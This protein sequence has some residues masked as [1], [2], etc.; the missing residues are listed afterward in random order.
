MFTHLSSS[1][2]FLLFNPP[3]VRG[4][5]RTTNIFPSDEN[6]KRMFSSC[7]FRFSLILRGWE[8]KMSDSRLN[9]IQWA[10]AQIIYFINEDPIV[11]IKWRKEKDSAFEQLHT[12]IKFSAQKERTWIRNVFKG[13][14]IETDLTMEL[15]NLERILTFLHWEFKYPF[16]FLQLPFIG[17]LSYWNKHNLNEE[18]KKHILRTG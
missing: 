4:I 14:G 1:M 8:M 2:V 15:A 3:A 13:N 18:R 17:R 7:T 5:F 12:K 16:Q 9:R 11:M 6:F 10:H